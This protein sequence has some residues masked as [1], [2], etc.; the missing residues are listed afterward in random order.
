MAGHLRA[1]PGDFLPMASGVS[2]PVFLYGTSI[3]A[4]TLSAGAQADPGRAFD[5]LKSAYIGQVY[6]GRITPEKITRESLMILERVFGD[7]AVDQILTHPF[8][9]LNFSTVRCRGP[10]AGESTA[11][12]AGGMLAAFG[13]N[14]VSRRTQA[15]LFRRTLFQA[16]GGA[17]LPERPFLFDGSGTTEVAL[18]R[19]NFRQ[20]LLASGSIPVIMEGIR[21]IPGAP[22][23][24]YRDGG[25][26]DYHPAVSLRDNAPGFI[27]YPHF[28]PRVT[29]GWFDK[30]LPWRTASDDLLDRTILICPSRDYICSLP[31]ARIPDRKDFIRFHGREAERFRVWNQAA[32]QSIE[33]GQAFLDAA[34]SGRLGEVARDFPNRL[35]T[36]I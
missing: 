17:D 30:N 22:S 18:T 11:A 24:M 2:H 8:L 10:L 5:R 27:L 26:L 15:L 3:G 1:L 20:A 28:Y 25:V 21:D 13:L 4:W 16:A 33:L 19:E 9:R 29:P 14:L 34:L 36:V 31:F 23:G 12:L 6:R 32:A 35:I 7:D